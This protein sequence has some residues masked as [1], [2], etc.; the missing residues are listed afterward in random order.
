MSTDGTQ[1]T[2]Q[3]ARGLLSPS[4]LGLAGTQALG[5]INDNIFRWLA[6]G[7]GKDFVSR[8]HASGILAAGLAC[9]VLPYLLL[10]APAGYLADRYSKRS[11]IVWCKVA[12][13]VLM[14]LGIASI[15][16]G[17]L[18]LMFGAVFLMGAQS[19][20]FGP[21]KFGSI[22]EL[23]P[24]NKI[25]S[26]NGA[27]GLVTVICTA[28]GAGIGNVLSDRMGYRGVE[29]S[30]WT[31]VAGVTIVS[32]AI[33][34]WLA[35][36]HIVAMPAANPDQSF[37]WNAATQTA[38]D[39]RLLASS[40]PMLRVAIG[41][42]FFWSLA[43]L[44]QMN[45][46]Q[47]AFEGGVVRQEDVAP[48][49]LALVAGLGIGSVLAGWWSA[50]RVELG[51]L[52]LGAAGLAISA[53][54]LSLVHGSLVSHESI[55]NGN[56]VL[57]C[58][59]L[60]LLGASA[61]LFDVPLA[62]YL[63]HRS[64]PQ[65]RGQILAATNFL[66][67]GGTLLSSGLFYV[68]RMPV[69]GGGP[70]FSARQIF[71]LA[72]LATVP[73]FLYIILLLPQASIRFVLWLAS[74]TV[75]RFRIHGLQNLP[76]RGGALL[77]A[78]HVSWIDGL[79]LL[80]TSSRPVRFVAYAP[81][82]Q[83]RGLSWLGRVMGIIPIGP[84]PKSI[85]KALSTAKQAIEN[86]ELVCI[87][88]EGGITRDGEVAA[89]KPGMLHIVGGTG[90]PIIPVFLDQ[91]W[92]SI[93]SYEGGR[94]LWKRP[95]RWPYVVSVHFGAP[96]NEPFDVAGVRQAVVQL[97]EEAVAVKPEASL[98]PPRSFVRMCRRLW[99]QPKLA[100]STG[101]QMTG[102]E[103]LMAAIIFRRLLLRE[104]L[105]PG[106][107]YV[108][109]LL[110]PSIGGVLSNVALTLAGRVAVNL[111]YTV[112][113]E[114]MNS[115]VSQCGI[116][117]VLTSKR[118]MKKFEHF[119]FEA[120]LIYLEDLLRKVTWKDKAI[121][122]MMAKLWPL[123]T[124]ERSLGLDK[125]SRDDLLTVIFTSGSTG[126]PKG[127]MLSHGNVASNIEGIASS[128]RLTTDDVLIGTL[129]FFHSYGFTAT[130]WSVLTL[131][132]MG[133]YHFSPLEA[134]VVGELCAKYRVTIFMSTPTFLRSYLKRCPPE[135]FTTVDAVF[136]SAE[137]L[138]SELCDAFAKKFGVRPLEAYGATE[139]SPLVS[140]N[141]PKH[142]APFEGGPW[143]KEGTVGR[144]IKGVNVKVLDPDTGETLPAGD[145]G[146]LWVSG[147]TVM[148]GYLNKPQ[149]TAEVIQ[150]GW[151]K[152]GDI[153]RVDADGFIEITGRLSRFSK[154]GGEMVPHLRIEDEINRVLNCDPETLCVAVTA[155]PDVKKGE[156]LVVLMLPA[157]K[158]PREITHE[159]AEA[160]LPN[161]W[162]P[163]TDSFFL[164]E[165]MP[166][167]GTGKLDLKKLKDWALEKTMH[168]ATAGA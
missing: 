156:R 48:M 14:L 96:L 19:A 101:K 125:M 31:T 120:K 47:F 22:P 80:L 1:T 116:T 112:S 153:A 49:L 121:A 43:S 106:E 74:H 3:P 145:A 166:V 130:M 109:L 27:L 90:A 152:T 84:G 55:W 61:G 26:A 167:L 64:P 124:L 6:I 110:P 160:G 114:I 46:D 50:G 9:F 18:Y 88:P 66:I 58:V 115:C 162:I 154:L 39:L 136:G 151:Y 105:K 113:N 21:A 168:P 93:F 2:A 69:D 102:G 35:S 148:K 41:E 159:L 161:L 75:Y 7:I 81:Y 70:M 72:G 44:A 77:V 51:I 76:E 98:I 60:G 67:F 13:I 30:L 23:L 85:K 25:S 138:S 149:Q 29:F 165:E 139:L 62:S 150:D 63:Q 65:A 164:V 107:K 42:V 140:V 146:M 142:R 131:E 111:N 4:F 57:T 24:A 52:P 104:V 16:V 147:P 78:N 87:F 53:V 40:R 103:T 54:W 33:A 163:G 155:V 119:Q 137:K 34:G 12:E 123:G 127:V 56:Y 129:P 11:V 8:E 117:H 37:P 28:L 68:L 132:P 108:G 157:E 99:K 73:V 100:D 38:R 143:V 10:A 95:R 133:V 17:N 83:I 91:L 135:H 118:V 92:G 128:V 134:G 122:F 144:P 59:L 71:L 141:V 97:G 89:F 36:L 82:V 15:V 45:I 20:L 158:T 79:V 126:D 32:I 86:G 94:L 5:T